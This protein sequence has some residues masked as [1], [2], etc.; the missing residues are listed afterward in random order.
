MQLNVLELF[1]DCLAEKNERVVEFG[2]AG[3]CNACAGNGLNRIS[4][5]RSSHK[6]I[7]F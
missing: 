5:Q 4:S 2:M 3:L 7:R 6:H 1:L